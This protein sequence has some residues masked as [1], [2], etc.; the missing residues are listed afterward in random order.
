MKRVIFVFSLIS[1]FLA[2]SCS[3][4]PTT[5]DTVQAAVVLKVSIP[6]PQISPTPVP[7]MVSAPI[8]LEVQKSLIVETG[9]NPE[10]D[11]FSRFVLGNDVS[12]WK[13]PLAQKCRRQSNASP[14]CSTILTRRQLE[15]KR[16]VRPKRSLSTKYGFGNVRP[17]I[18][19]GEVINW[20]KLRHSSVGSMIKNFSRLKLAD[21]LAL[22]RR[23]EFETTC[24]NNTAIAI[25][26]TLEDSLPT[27]SEPG[28]IASLY[29]KGADCISQSPPDQ[30]MLLTRAGMFYFMKKDYKQASRVFEK[31]KSLDVPYT[32]RPL[33]WLAR[34]KGEMGERREEKRLIE[35]LRTR[36]PFSFHT[37]V[38]LTR[39]KIDPGEILKRTANSTRRSQQN[40]QVNTLIEQVETLKMAG[41][42]AAASRVL[43]WAS[44]ESQGHEPEVRLYLAE[45][46]HDS[47]D[48]LSRIA[49]LSDILYKNPHLVSGQS[50]DLYFP[51]AFFPAF[52]TNIAGLDPNLLL[53]VARQESAFNPRA[54]SIANARGLLQILPRTGRKFKKRLD[55]Y[56]P[57]SNIEVGSRYLYELLRHLNGNLPLAL[58]SYNAGPERVSNWINRYPVDNPVLFTDLIPFRETREYV[59]SVLRNYYWY[60]RMNSAG[61]EKFVDLVFEAQLSPER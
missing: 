56:D 6:G 3:N 22:K 11:Q 47:S 2:S 34:C 61:D 46:K 25:A 52:E 5:N 55:L 24:P 48:H 15:E 12:G 53:A 59:A 44:A 57:N 37:L 20:E 50:M 18:L 13:N 1:G 9:Q 26:S 8:G 58:A 7:S 33:Y 16:K 39:D 21:V 10:L 60:R 23:A 41:F 43:D 17:L 28:D 51:K 54:R 40:P 49:M 35:V 42:T 19:D 30:E 29:E 36:Y 32:G 27:T 38:A 14:F 31:A 45:L 4:S